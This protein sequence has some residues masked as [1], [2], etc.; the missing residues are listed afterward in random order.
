M[1]RITLA[2]RARY[3]FDNTMSKGAAAL[4]GWLFLLSGA[5][6][7]LTGAVLVLFGLAPDGES[8]EAE[9]FFSSTWRALMHAIDTGTVTGE[10]GSRTYLAIMFATTLGGIFVVSVL[11]GLLT[12]GIQEKLTELRKGRSFVVEEGHTLIL[13]WSAQ[14]YTIVSELVI[15]NESLKRAA[16]VVLSEQD[17]VAMDDALRQHVGDTKTTRVVCRTGSPIDLDHLA[18]VNPEGARSIVVL[19]PEGPDPDAHVIKV[20]LALLNGRHRIP[21]SC[22]IV[23]EIRDARNVEPVEL[24]GRGQV[25]VVLVEDL[26]S[27]ITVQTCRQSGLSVVY[28]ELLDFAGDEFY[29]ACLPELAGKTFSEAL[30]CFERCAL[31]GIKREGKVELGPDLGLVLR[32]DDEVIV[33]AEDDAT[34]RVEL[35]EPRFD[36]TKLHRSTR[37]PAPPERTLILGFNRRAELIL[38]QL[39]AY[40]AEGSEALVVADVDDLDERLG[41][42]RLE[43]LGLGWRR[44]DTTSRALLDGLELGSFDHVITLSYAE[45]LDVQRADART[46]VTLLHLRDIA[47]KT[48]AAFS[49]VSEILD[50]KNRELAEVTKADD[51]IVSDRLVS[52]VLAQI[53][54]ARDRAAVFRDLF[55]SSGKEIYL[56]PVSEYLEPGGE[57]DFYTVLEGAKRRG[58]IAMGYRLARHADDAER[59]YGIRVNPVKSERIAF[60]ESDKIIVLAED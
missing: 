45:K 29:L 25:E 19:S 60:A 58:E 8:G 53:A 18:I 52:L 23:A 46:L 5:L 38:E 28:G 33:V 12:S 47:Q 51:F 55:D 41:G 16:I 36:E 30:F 3:W 20:L 56:R 31:V 26:I 49:V 22:H 59:D 57:V 48:G 10:S 24:V 35:Q 13:G 17:K 42:V 2:D 15:A 37:V 1:R 11:I 34:V 50:V 40:V 21:E 44:G 32:A 7:T 6:I 14:V 39:D 43:K 4:I 27:R 9:G 54:E